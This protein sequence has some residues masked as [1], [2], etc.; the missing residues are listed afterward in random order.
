MYKKFIILFLAFMIS[1]M[2]FMSCSDDDGGGTAPGPDITVTSPNGGDVVQMG[3]SV[4]ITWE[5]YDGDSIR[6][7]LYKG[8][9]LSAEIETSYPNTGSY[10]ST[11][12]TDIVS[13][14]DYK[15]KI[16][17]T[18]NS[19][20]YDFSNANF[21]IVSVGEYIVVTAPNGG[22]TYQAGQTYTITWEDNIDASV[23][24]EVFK[25]G[26]YVASIASSTTSDGSHTT[27][28][29]NDA[30]AGADYKIKITSV[31]NASITD[32]SNNNFTITVDP[33]AIQV[34]FPNGG[35]N[36][37]IGQTYWI[38]WEDNIAGDVR[39]EFYE[40]GTLIPEG[41]IDNAGSN[42]WYQ[43]DIPLDAEP[44]DRITIK[45]ISID[46]PSIYDWSDG[47]FS[48]IAGVDDGDSTPEDANAVTVPHTGNY[49][50]HQMGDVDWFRVYLDSGREYFFEN[51]SNVD[52][53]SEFHLYGPGNASGTDIGYEEADND[54]GEWQNGLQPQIL[55]TP[56]TSGYYYLRVAYYSNN[57]A[58]TK[59]ES[60]AGPYTLSI[61]EVSDR[62]K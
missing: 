16:T 4:T 34:E 43:L 36:L 32:F 60:Q 25:G 21:T 59:Q 50:I 10:T 9:V 11:I 17:S 45:I 1:G 41:T 29:P 14:I 6:I 27:E 44:I 57:P 18:T 13:G 7:E 30:E 35:E 33:P 26:S 40:N 54:D 3:T 22:E 12:P 39:I 19:S 49:E 20:I 46:T 56:S 24:I 23:M 58:K 8:G 38:E 42:E 48:V 31:V 2:I 28:I 55:Y 5:D 15:I 62:K 52:F 37:I 53:D 51:T 47:S 61:T